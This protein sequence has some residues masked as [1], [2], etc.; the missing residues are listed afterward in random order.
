MNRVTYKY[1]QHGVD[2]YV[3]PLC[4][5]V[6]MNLEGVLC[7]SYSSNIEQLEKE[8][9]SFRNQA[10]HSVLMNSFAI[11]KIYAI[12]IPFIPSRILWEKMT[13]TAGR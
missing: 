12:N 10:F 4:A 5:V 7:A 8:D 3:C 13:G 9:I 2:T 1:E 11:G 6:Y